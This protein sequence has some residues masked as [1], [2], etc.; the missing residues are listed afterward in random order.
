MLLTSS[1]DLLAFLAPINAEAKL[2]LWLWANGY[3]AISYQVVDSGYRAVVHVPDPMCVED[4]YYKVFVDT[5]GVI[6]ETETLMS[7]APEVCS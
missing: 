1:A 2:N 6:T 4:Y 7:R 3:Q 5:N